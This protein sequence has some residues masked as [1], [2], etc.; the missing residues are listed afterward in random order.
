MYGDKITAKERI[1]KKPSA[2][3]KALMNKSN[4]AYAKQGVKEAHKKPI[5]K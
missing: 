4:K 3:H 2:L 5:K 1:G